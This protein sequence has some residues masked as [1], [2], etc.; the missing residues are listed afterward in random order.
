M[1]R[2]VSNGGASNPLGDSS[3]KLGGGLSDPAKFVQEPMG[4]AITAMQMHYK[5]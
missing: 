1:D 3:H 4:G 2:V 5:E